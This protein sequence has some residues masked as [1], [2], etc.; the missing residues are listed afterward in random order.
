[1]KPVSP[2][3]E[4]CHCVQKLSQHLSLS[5][6][7]TVSALDE[8]IVGE[9]FGRGGNPTG[10][11][12]DVTTRQYT[13]GSL[14][15]TKTTDRPL[16]A[17]IDKAFSRQNEAPPGSMLS[18]TAPGC[19]RA[20]QATNGG[21]MCSCAP[22]QVFPE[23]LNPQEVVQLSAWKSEGALGTDSTHRFVALKVSW[24]VGPVVFPLFFHYF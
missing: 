4:T 7:T 22:L 10:E 15:Q 16:L 5:G 20:H 8:N 6:F 17:S 13:H 2:N 9:R 3:C 11:G 1:M 12:Y 24:I 19:K 14:T 23:D 18:A 21:K